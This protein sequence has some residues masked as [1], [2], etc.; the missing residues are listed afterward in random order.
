MV[1][2]KNNLSVV[3]FLVIASV[4]L[5]FAIGFSVKGKSS[6]STDSLGNDNNFAPAGEGA[7]N[8]DAL[9]LAELSERLSNIMLPDEEYEKLRDA[10]HKT[11]MGLFASQANGLA[12]NAS[13]QADAELRKSVDE[14]YSREYFTKMNSSSMQ[15]LSEANLRVI[16]GFYGTDAGKKFLTLSPKIIES[17]MR[18]VQSDLSSWLPNAVAGVVNK[19][20]NPGAPAEAPLNGKNDAEANP[21][22][23]GE[24]KN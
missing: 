21:D 15:E 5:G 17:T 13:A 3:A 6:K 7:E 16:L 10:I 23:L 24:A 14:K 22:D 12:E 2:G 9:S 20:K 19:I 11:A 8:L 4:G 1:L 18:T